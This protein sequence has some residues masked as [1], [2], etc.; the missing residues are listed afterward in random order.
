MSVSTS[1]TTSTQGLFSSIRAQT[2]ALE[3]QALSPHASLSREATREQDEPPC[4]IRTAF[5]RD[6]DRIVH[7]KAF[8]RLKHKTQVFVS[9]TGDHDRTRLTHT[10][11]VAQISRTVARALRLNEDL[12]EAIALGHDLGHPPFG[13]SGEQ[14]LNKLSSNGF[15]HAE[16]SLR[17]VTTLEKLNLTRQTLT[18]LAQQ[19]GQRVEGAPLEGC[20]VELCDRIAYLHHD[21]ED[22]QR[23]GL[24]ADDALPAE[25]AETLGTTRHQRLNR[26]IEDL[27]RNSLAE[28]GSNQPRIGFSEDVHKAVMALRKWMFDNVYHHP[29]QTA[30]ERKIERVLS[31][32]YLT[33][34]QA[35]DE[36]PDEIRARLP[37]GQP[38]IDVLDRVILDYIAGM[39]DR[40]A[41]STYQQLLLPVCL[42]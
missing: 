17:L 34:F 32:L 9:P 11:E 39:T 22:A 2:E 28:L 23:A 29:S 6:R 38:P 15:R 21:W 14:V 20:V 4:D 8:R 33:Y 42:A 10:L 40:Y 18:G 24:I 36:L 19:A 30:Q 41:L 25:L 3:A 35:P 27:V 13:H 16:H 12:T 5:Q 26:M 31:G 37:E 7:A 1:P